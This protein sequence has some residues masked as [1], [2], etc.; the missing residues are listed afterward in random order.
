MHQERLANV[1]KTETIKKK[2]EKDEPL[3]LPLTARGVLKSLG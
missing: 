1:F 3:P 2:K